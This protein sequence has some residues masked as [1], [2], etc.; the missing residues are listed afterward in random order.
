MP[1]A[2]IPEALEDIRQG[3]MVILVDDEDRE[4]EGDLY[5]A[6]EKATPEAINFMARYGRGLI[7]LTLTHDWV[8]RL[9]L[10]MMVSQ[11]RSKFETAFTVSIEARVGVTTGISAAD[12]ARTVLA[13]IADSAKPDDLVSPG[14]VFPIRARKGGVLVR[15]GQTEGSV[16]LSRLAGMKPA[17]VICEVM[18]D[19]GTMARMPD[20]EKF[21]EEHD[22]KIVTIADVIQYRMQNE[23][24]VHRGAIAALPTASGGEFQVIA[25]TNDIDDYTHLALVKGDLRPDEDILVRVHSEC[26]TGD[27]FGSL[28]C[29]CGGQLRAAML[30]IGK[31]G[32]GVIL[33]MRNHEGRGI[34]L[35]NKIKAYGLQE[36][37][38]DTVEANQALG[39]EADLRDYGIGAQMLVDLGIKKMRLMTNNPKKLVGLQGYGIRIVE[40]VPLEIPPN[41]CNI[42]YLTTKCTKMGHLLSCV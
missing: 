37:G 2:S 28:R 10:P 32:K 1:L 33:Y 20:L 16:D 23:I 11:N 27:V 13:A 5:M 3:K 41:E 40:R 36:Q 8:E 12:R 35:L 9:R 21:A 39:L 38:M 31:E 18:K 17:G 22:L 7:C 14:H 25:Y 19:D 4:N 34:G 29:D 26:L 6:A 15:T 24:F 42:D 30:R